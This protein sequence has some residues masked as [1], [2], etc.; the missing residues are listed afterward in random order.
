M[1]ASSIY[2]LLP[3]W[4]LLVSSTKSSGDLFTSPSLWFSHWGLAGNLHSLNSI[5]GG[6]YYRWLVNSF[7]YAVGGAFVATIIAAMAGY[8]FA[9]YRI[10][11][12]ESM[13]NVVLA[14]VL[15]PPPLFALPLYLLFSKIH[16]VNTIWAV[17]LPAFVTPF[18]VYLARI[19]ASASVP[20]ELLEAARLDGA[21]DLRIFR[22]IAVPI[23]SPAMVTIFLFQFVTIWSNFLL[24]SLM[25]ASDH[26][27]PVTVGLVNWQ[28][29]HGQIAPFST[30]ITG[31]FISV[32]PI[33]AMFLCLQRFWRSGITAGSLK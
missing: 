25:L 8:A 12:K 9:K 30:V 32:L 18:G 24:P 20:D 27:Q 3:V 26:L 5:D 10:R 28:A 29:Q 31:A 23:M 1:T 16:V 22:T 17:L 15:I 21:G 13:F 14:S 6:I 7:L 4:W 2:F 33:I 19:Y 11:G